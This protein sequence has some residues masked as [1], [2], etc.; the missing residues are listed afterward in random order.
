MLA[1][2]TAHAER[3]DRYQPLDVSSDGQQAATVDLANKRTIISGNVVVRQGTLL[4]KA[5]RVEVREMPSGHYA[6]VATGSPTTFRQRRDVTGEWVEAQGQRVEYDGQAQ[7]VRISGNARLRVL[8]NGQVGDEASAAVIVY[9]QTSDTVRF[10]G[11]AAPPGQAVS[12]GGD[13]RARIVFVPRARPAA[14]A[15]AASAAS[16]AG[17]P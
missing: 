10:E 17:T 8:R 3:A 2:A 9:E 6:A 7:S 13:G 4:L 16:A 5:D 11:R 1:L 14:P 12:A 15:P